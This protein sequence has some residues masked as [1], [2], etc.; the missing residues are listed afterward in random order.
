MS[1]VVNNNIASLI[2]QRNLGNNTSNL[3]KSIERL[4]SGFKINHAS[5]DAAGLSISENL[6]GQIRGNKQAINNVQDGI[7][8]LQIAESGLTVMNENIQRIREL[9]VQAANDTNATSEKNAILSEINARIADLDRIA[10]ATKFN[11][12]GLLDGSLTV[13]QLQIGPG[14]SSTNALDLSSVLTKSNASTLGISLNTTGAT[15]T[16]TK[17]RSYLSS[18]STALNII[19][20]QRSNLGAFQNRLESAYENLSAMTENLQSAESRIRDVDV[21]EETANMTKYQILQ[22]ASAIVLAQSNRLPQI[23]LTLLQG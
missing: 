7:N 10:L 11:G 15:W 3:I 21:A 9:C 16:S 19:T 8:L 14:A 4:S 5:D 12:I 20:S 13:L 1:I 17:I 23:A 2:A 6:R 18:L 22:Q